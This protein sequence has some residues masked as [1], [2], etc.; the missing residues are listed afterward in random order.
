[1]TPAVVEPGPNTKAADQLL[2]A[3]ATAGSNGDLTKNYDGGNAAYAGSVKFGSGDPAGFTER[4]KEDPRMV[5]ALQRLGALQA[6]REELN[7]E[8][9]QLTL[10]RNSE[11]D[12]RKM[13][14]LTEKLGQKE[15]AEQK[16]VVAKTKRIIDDTVETPPP[17]PAPPK[18]P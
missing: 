2:S 14:A 7:A 3:A 9:D 17:Q 5:A 15:L 4:E 8:R 16:E 18:K 1:V 10:A 6:R 11:K 13:Q 12:Q